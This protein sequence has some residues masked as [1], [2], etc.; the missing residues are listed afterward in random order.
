MCAGI[1]VR[2][3]LMRASSC[4]EPCF[5]G[6]EPRASGGGEVIGSS[7]FCWRIRTGEMPGSKSAISSNLLRDFDINGVSGFSDEDLGGSEGRLM[8]S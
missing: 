4:S 1:E 3:E 8:G 6:E 5:E 7:L 2:M